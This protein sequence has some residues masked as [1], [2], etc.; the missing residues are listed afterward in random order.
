MTLTV[1]RRGLEY[2]PHELSRFPLLWRTI[3][4]VLSTQAW[5]LRICPWE[6][7][8]KLFVKRSRQ[9][10]CCLQHSTAAQRKRAKLR[11]AEKQGISP[12]GPTSEDSK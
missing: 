5:R 9:E 4:M 7:C 10:Y 11:A 2:T 3:E 8:R 1:R 6:K 12:I